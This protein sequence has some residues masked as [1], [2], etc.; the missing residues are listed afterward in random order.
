M[1]PYKPPTR[2][3][4]FSSRINL[5]YT[6]HVNPARYLDSI[7]REH[8]SFMI[9]LNVI[10]LSTAWTQIG[11]IMQC[12]HDIDGNLINIFPSINQFLN[13]MPSMR[14]RWRSHMILYTSNSCMACMRRI[15]GKE[16]IQTNLEA[17]RPEQSERSQQY[18][19][20]TYKSKANV[21]YWLCLIE[22]FIG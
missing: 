11:R 12:P 6:S 15:D 7:I 21:I 17:N 10:S 2:Q 18:R 16:I 20:H 9:M 1:P 5:N 4:Q 19:I 3:A 22:F 13:M 8:N 14:I